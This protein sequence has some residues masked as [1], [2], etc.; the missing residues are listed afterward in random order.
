MRLLVF[1]PSFLEPAFVLGDW[2]TDDYC[3]SYLNYY[4]Y[5]FLCVQAKLLF[6]AHLE[7]HLQAY[8]YLV[9]Q[10]ICDKEL[11]TSLEEAE[12]YGALG[13]TITTFY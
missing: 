11:F 3:A 13:Y 1:G 12:F 2:K 4:W 6:A 10:I 8:N 7:A 9:Y 5:L